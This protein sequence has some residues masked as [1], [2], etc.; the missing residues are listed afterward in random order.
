MERNKKEYII[1][2][3]LLAIVLI[4]GMTRLQTPLLFARLLI[5]LGIGYVLARAAYGFA[6]TANR[7]YNSGS[8][9]LMRSF[10]FLIILA[11]FFTVALVAV[12]ASDVKPEYLVNY[13]LFIHPVTIGALVGAFM[14]GVGMSF[15]GGCASGQL[16]DMTNAFPRALIGVLFFG[17][18]RVIAAPLDKSMNSLINESLLKSSV[19][20]NGVWFPDL[21]KFDGLNGFL[22]ALVLTII[23][24]LIVIELSYAYERKRK[25]KGTYSLVES[26]E[27]SE[28]AL[29]NI[30]DINATWYERIFTRPWTLA[31]GAIGM[32]VMYAVLMGFTKGAWGVSGAFGFWA[33]KILSIFVGAD[34]VNSYTG[35]EKYLADTLFTHQQS[36]Q[37]MGIIL[38]AFIALFTMGRLIANFKQGLKISGK[39]ALLAVVGG[40]LMGVGTILAKGCNAGG[41]FSPI[42][43]F[44]L[45]GWIFL[46]LMTCGAFFGNMLLKSR[47]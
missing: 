4:L 21:F 34:A 40:L 20:T 26:E 44:S 19:E 16:T 10:M 47:K 33:G 31:E 38:G 46:I 30:R 45:S 15:A 32:A 42:V 35:N 9:K 6:G 37:D 41:L 28:K 25:E 36:V 43:S 2:F 17:L 18:G 22:G 23:L 12:P 1:G 3:V 29:L 14:F 39:D 24:A 5:G 8:T 7:A 13:G 27:E 11:S